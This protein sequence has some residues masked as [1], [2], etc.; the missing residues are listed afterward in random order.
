MKIENIFTP[1]FERQLHFSVQTALKY[2]GGILSPVKPTRLP[3]GGTEVT[4]MRD[5]STGD[6]PSRIDWGICAR[7]DELWVRVYGGTAQR[8]VYL[9]LD[10]SYGMAF[11][12]KK[13]TAARRAAAV[14]AAGL[15]TSGAL[16]EFGTFTPDFTL[17]PV[18]CHAQKM[19]KFLRFLE[20]MKL[21]DKPNLVDFG[22]LAEAFLAMKR[23]PGEVYVLSDFFGESDS[24]ERDFAEG[25]E[26]LTAAGFSCRAIHLT[27]PVDRAENFVGDVDI[28]DASRDYRQV[29]TL[30]E[31]DLAA[32][33]R[34]YDDYIA[35]VGV[36]FERRGISYTQVSA[37]ETE[38]GVFFQALGL[39][40]GAATANPWEEYI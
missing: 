7:H 37:G 12:P 34:L 29:I 27:D 5:Y 30:T 8:R 25:F 15:L 10:T 4:G 38:G 1:E 40:A 16:L 28:Y 32:Y 14:L 23:E 9:L 6:D 13:F 24:F 11:R 3:A 20:G 2:G 18:L 22:F 35:S 31:R 19:G 21:S 17:F 26:K 36:F 39:P 33:Q